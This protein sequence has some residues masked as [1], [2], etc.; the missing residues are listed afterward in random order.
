MN[1]RTVVVTGVSRGLGLE[2]AKALLAEGYRVVGL[3]RGESEAFTALG[4]DYPEQVAYVRADMT[5]L[6]GLADV[7]RHI[8]KAFGPIYGLVNNAGIGMGGVLATMHQADMERV[9]ATNLLGPMTLTKYMMRSMLAKK[10]GRIINISSIAAQSGFHAMSVYA[11]SKAGLEGFSRALAREAGKYKVTVNCV[12]PGFV[13]TD[14]TEGYDEEQVASIRRRAPLGLPTADQVAGAVLYL[15]SPAA[16][17][18][19]GT[20]MTVDGGSSA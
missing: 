12:A 6:A 18:V 17:N 2:L 19:T 7:A 9:I 16:A 1:G 11:A 13:E 14:M 20:V 4:S 15:L 5:D 8:G 3:G 10:E